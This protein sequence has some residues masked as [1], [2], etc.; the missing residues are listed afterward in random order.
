MIIPHCCMKKLFGY[1]VLLC[2]AMTLVGCGGEDKPVIDPVTPII[3]G[4]SLLMGATNVSAEPQ[5]IIILFDREIVLN[6]ASLVTLTP[7]A[8]LEVVAEERKLLIRI[9]EKL[10]YNTEY[11]LTIGEGVVVDKVT[12]GENMARTILFR[13]EEGPYVPPTELT[14]K[15]VTDNAL[16]ITQEL[17][18]FMWGLYGKA[19]LSGA[20]SIG[21]W[22]LKECEWVKSFTGVYPVVASFDY[23]Y[24]HRSPSNA[25]DYSDISPAEKWWSEGGFVAIDW[26]W[27]V[28]SAEG[29]K[30]Y[31]L[32]RDGT[33]VRI[34][35]MLTE[36]TWEYAQMMRDF[37]E[38]AD[39][40]LRLQ[41]KNIPV[42]WRPI[43]E[44]QNP[45]NCTVGTSDYY[46]WADASA[47]EYKGLWQK[48]FNYFE[49]R[50]V[51]N[52]VWVWTSQI[53]DIKYYP[54]EEYVDMVSLDL[55]NRPTSAEMAALWSKID[56]YFPHKMV[57]LGE[58][59]NLPAVGSQMASGAYWSYF[60]THSD[61][62][63]NFSEGYAHR[64]ATME[65][66]RSTLA[67]ERVFSRTSIS[68]L[69]SYKA[70]RAL[71]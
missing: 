7:S 55:Y 65:W 39:M 27:M 45:Q 67:D 56:E 32:L 30:Q 58:M 64:Y 43:P 17:Y 16:P 8:T 59:G 25:I 54:G 3:K 46:W 66:W 20:M 9:I 68:A 18:S 28:P 23:Q 69:N 57:T 52:L 4:Q 41:E 21:G 33:T 49:E 31:S 42:L 10:A 47:E 19:S 37:N 6:D 36:G 34:K 51:R 71:K 24:I 53:Q 11:E 12:L 26:H 44:T 60:V 38:V 70:M 15:L 62:N 61:L 48:M 22:D 63:N 5:T 29:A 40:L 35:N 50:G 1:I 14:T 2:A 13:T